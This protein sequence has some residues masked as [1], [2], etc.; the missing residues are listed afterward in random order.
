MR[1]ASYENPHDFIS[2][3]HTLTGQPQPRPLAE[4]HA[5]VEERLKIV[6]ISSPHIHSVAA[7][8]A[9]YVNAFSQPKPGEQRVL[10]SLV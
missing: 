7:A 8:G 5:S 4:Q 3:K 1:P 10:E 6:P 2:N 9:F